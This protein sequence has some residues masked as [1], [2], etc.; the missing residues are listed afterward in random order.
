[1]DR[2]DGGA[3][4]AAGRGGQQR[5]DRAAADA[6]GGGVRRRELGCGA[7]GEPDGRHVLDAR[8]DPRDA[9]ADRAG[10]SGGQA[11]GDGGRR[12]RHEHP[13]ER[14]VPDERG[15]RGGQAWCDGVDQDGREGLRRKGDPC[16]CHV[17]VSGGLSWLGR[18]FCEDADFFPSLGA[19]VER[20]F[21]R[22]PKEN[23][24]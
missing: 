3:V 2:G 16:E 8:T 9:A 22:M 7:G 1:M 19:S 20:R 23:W 21:L 11:R 14:V 18:L 4:R 17:A 15:V 13:G 12:Q 24:V 10:A 5:G 6:A